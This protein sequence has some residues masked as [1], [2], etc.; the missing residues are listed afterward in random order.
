MRAYAGLSGGWSAVA[1]AGVRSMEHVMCGRRRTAGV[2]V[3]QAE[4]LLLARLCFGPSAQAGGC[5]AHQRGVGGGEEG[6]GAKGA[7]AAGRAARHAPA[8]SPMSALRSTPAL[9]TTSSCGRGARYADTPPSMASSKGPGAGPCGRVGGRVL[10]V[11]V[12]W[13][14]ATGCG[15][16]RVCATARG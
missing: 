7:G 15:M 5:K 8:S 6:G 16:Q 4:A 12:L 1:R 3:R 11:R 10:R 14:P 13:V 2:A 9:L